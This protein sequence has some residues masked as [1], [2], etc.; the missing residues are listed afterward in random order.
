M[1]DLRFRRLLSGGQVLSLLAPEE[2]FD[3]GN[4]TRVFYLNQ[5]KTNAKYFEFVYSL[6]R[7][8]QDVCSFLFSNFQSP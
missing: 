7:A 6:K 5:N 8:H 2:S 4:L 3:V 1:A